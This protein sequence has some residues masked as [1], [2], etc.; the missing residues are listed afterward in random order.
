MQDRIDAERLIAK[1]DITDEELANAAN[2]TLY[3]AS[4]TFRRVAEKRRDSQTAGEN[5]R[6]FHRKTV[7][8]RRLNG[9]QCRRMRLPDSFVLKASRSWRKLPLFW[10]TLHPISFPE[11]SSAERLLRP[12]LSGILGNSKR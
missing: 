3:T 12:R 10:K 7:S 4:R 1:L 5:C 11:D 9:S 8:A 6:A 2:K